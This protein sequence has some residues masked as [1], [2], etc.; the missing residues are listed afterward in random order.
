MEF[1]DISLTDMQIFIETYQRKSFSEAAQ[2][3]FLS[4][5]S[6]AR[7]IESIENVFDVKLFSR[8]SSGIIPTKA[9]EEFYASCVPLVQNAYNLV[10]HMK[11]FNRNLQQE[12]KFGFLGYIR[13]TSKARRIIEKFMENYPEIVVHQFD[14]DGKNPM[15]LIKT[16]ELD[17]AFVNLEV[18]ANDQELDSICLEEEKYLLIVHKNHPLAH[19]LTVSANDVEKTPI[20]F[21]SRYR[22]AVQIFESWMRS[23]GVD[24]SK[25]KLINSGDIDFIRTSVMEDQSA[26]FMLDSAANILINSSPSL[27]G[28][29][30]SPPLCRHSG[31][32]FRKGADMQEHHRRLIDFFNR[33]FS[34]RKQDSNS[35][36]I[37]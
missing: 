35:S 31:L 14:L 28:L 32:L 24:S 18:Y 13:N 23:S 26:A 22:I 15:D 12:I 10:S 9:G 7:S 4:R 17:L 11:G 16:G 29:H 25:A 5:Q 37:C 8:T 36:T 27:V 1:L 20:F 34:A 19:R 33:E 3:L 6:V 2:A 30:V 21:M